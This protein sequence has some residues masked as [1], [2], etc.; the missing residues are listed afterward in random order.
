METDLNLEQL[1]DRE[2]VHALLGTKPKAG[3]CAESREAYAAEALDALTSSDPLVLRRALSLT[4]AAARRLAAAVELHR[5]LLRA[6]R[7]R[8]ALTQPELVAQVMMPLTQRDHECLWCLALDPRS[9]L[10]GEPMQVSQGDIDGCDAGP[11]AFFRY[12][13]SRGATTAIAVHNHPTGDPA[14]SAADAAVTRRL[15]AAG[16]AVDVALV[17]HVIATATGAFASLRRHQPELFR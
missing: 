11:R 4:P 9:Q 1:T 15:V 3:F 10:I 7:P 8:T 6:R 2:V 12:A 16:R 13:L 17:D 5:R 14:P